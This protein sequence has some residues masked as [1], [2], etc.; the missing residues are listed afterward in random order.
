[1][2]KMARY[3]LRRE[4][5]VGRILLDVAEKTGKS[6]WT[7]FGDFVECAALAI[8]NRVDLAPYDARE[9]RYMEIVRSYADPDHFRLFAKAMVE[10]QKLYLADPCGSDVLGTLFQ[11]MDLANSH[12]GQFF[13]PF[14]VSYMMAQMTMSD[15]REKVEQDGFITMCDPCSGAGGMAIAAAKAVLE[16]DLNPTTCMHVAAIDIDRRCVHMTYV[17]LSMLSIPAV[18]SHG[19]SLRLTFDEHWF[20]PEHVTGGWSRRLRRQTEMD[21]ATVQWAGLAVPERVAFLR[22]HEQS[23]AAA[24]KPRPPENLIRELAAAE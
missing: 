15:I 10:L 1:M 14:N 4:N 5:P 23:L 21:V 9:A 6:L 2:K 20:T 22:Q 8:S 3:R 18:V 7:V 12:A 16:Q 17:Q 24:L 19:N 11:D 13:T